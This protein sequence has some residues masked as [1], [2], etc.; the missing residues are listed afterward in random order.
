MNNGNCSEFIKLPQLQD[1][2]FNFNCIVIDTGKILTS[3]RSKVVP[4]GAPAFVV[5]S[6]LFRL[7]ASSSNCVQKLHIVVCLCLSVI[8]PDSSPIS[9][10]ICIRIILGWPK[11]NFSFPNIFRLA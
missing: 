6:W 5:I 10:K 3:Q 9:L 1:L 2:P 7:V 11:R 4:T 8:V